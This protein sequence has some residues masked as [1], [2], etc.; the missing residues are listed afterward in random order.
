MLIAS[1]LVFSHYT[2]RSHIMVQ[3]VQYNLCHCYL[4]GLLRKDILVNLSAP[5]AIEEASYC[6]GGR[7][8]DWCHCMS[9]TE[10]NVESS[11]G[12]KTAQ[13]AKWFI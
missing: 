13:R 5:I 6:R 11:G 9:A 7:S 8:I 2:A 3:T 1:A 4:I 10:E 12:S